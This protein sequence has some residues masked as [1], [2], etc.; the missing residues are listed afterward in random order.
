MTEL[1][2]LYNDP[3]SNPPPGWVT[4][5]YW[6]ATLSSPNQHGHVSLFNGN[7]TFASADTNTVYVAFQVL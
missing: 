4:A 7:Q 6:S 5:N 2:A 1:L 3:L